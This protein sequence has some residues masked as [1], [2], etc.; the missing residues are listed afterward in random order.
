MHIPQ[1]NWPLELAKTRCRCCFRLELE[2]Q[3]D[4]LTRSPAAAAS[5]LDAAA[6]AAATWKTK[7][8]EPLAS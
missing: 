4:L 7:P 5:G 3:V 8:S 6:P 2:E 1:T